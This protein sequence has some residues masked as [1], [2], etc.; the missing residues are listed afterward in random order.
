MKGPVEVNPEDDAMAHVFALQRAYPRLFQK[1]S[2]LGVW[3]PKG[4]DGILQQLCGAVNALL[5]DHQAKL[6]RVDQVKEKFGTLRF[7][8]SVAGKTKLTIDA[9]SSE[10]HLRVANSP[11]YRKGFP[12]DVIDALIREAEASTCV[13]CAKCGKPGVLRTQ[14]WHRVACDDCLAKQSSEP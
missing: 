7:Y 4:W 14:G 8:Y 11:K 6:F 5:D 2:P 12:A 3:Y 9:Q 13:T 1:G 10:Q